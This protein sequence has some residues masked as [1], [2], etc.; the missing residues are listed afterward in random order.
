VP[1]QILLEGTLRE[2]ASERLEAI[3]ED[4]SRLDGKSAGDASLASGLAGQAILHGYLAHAGYGQHHAGV[5]VR[6]LQDAMAA[7]SNKP[8]EASLFS[9]LTGVGWAQAHLRGWVPGLDGEA[10]CAEIDEVLL[11]HLEQSPWR[12]DYDLISGLVGF[13]VYAL[14]QM[15]VARPESSKGVVQSSTPFVDS[16]R[17]VP[18]LERVIDHLAETAERRGDG[19]TWWTN[20]AWLPAEG[21]EKSPRGYYNLGLAHGVPGVIALLGLACAAGIARGQAEPLLEGAVNWLLAQQGPGGFAHWVDPKNTDGPARLAWCYGDPGVAA[22]LLSTAR[23]VAKPAWEDEA[24][25]IAQRAARRPDE[26][27][28]VRDAGLCHGAAGLGH[29]FNRM[30]Q[31]T[32]EQE[33]ANAARFWFEQSLH[34]AQPG[35]GI[36]GY[37]SWQLGHDGQ[38]TWETDPGLLTGSIGIALA[39][40]AAT[41]NVEPVWDRMLLTAI[42]LSGNGMHER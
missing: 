3:L 22:A 18:C 38:P 21:R 4:L 20:P 28:G 36:G 11:H 31:A 17:A 6:C 13:G 29:L 25:A 24:M 39:L 41:T 1:W 34:M 30:F 26:Q 40:L 15:R 19:I 23:C 32:G 35:Q 10:D 8:M 37:Q 16:G 5:A 2:R 9:G 14:E 7:M 12:D 42:P 33:F 27:A